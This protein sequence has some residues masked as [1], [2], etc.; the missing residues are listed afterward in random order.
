MQ[1]EALRMTFHFHTE[2]DTSGW[3]PLLLRVLMF[4]KA[5]LTNKIKLSRDVLTG[6]VTN[7]K[8]IRRTKFKRALT[9][10]S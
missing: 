2:Q 1:R 3:Y 8:K 10:R 6:R 9:F 5:T 4:E 7:T